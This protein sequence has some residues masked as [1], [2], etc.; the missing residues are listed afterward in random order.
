MF[1]PVDS[2]GTAFVLIATLLVKQIST[3][4]DVRAILE[5]ATRPEDRVKLGSLLAEIVHQAANVGSER[6][7]PVQ[8][9]AAHPDVLSW[10][11]TAL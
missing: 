3:Q 11:N 1:E 8:S 4:A 9:R 10:L 6:R 5:N 2:A 7:A